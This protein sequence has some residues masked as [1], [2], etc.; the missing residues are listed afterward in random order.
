[1][2]LNLDRLSMEAAREVRSLREEIDQRVRRHQAKVLAAFQQVRV[3]EYLFRPSTGYGYGDRGREVLEELFAAVFHAEAALVRSQIVSGTHAI[4]LGMFGVLRPG[5]EMLLATGQPYDTLQPVVGMSTRAVGSLREWGVSVNQVDLTPEGAPDLAS[6]QVAVNPKTRLVFI[7]RSR[8]YSLRQP[9]RIEQIKLI[10]DVVRRANPEAVCLVDNC[11]G[12]FVEDME[13]TQVGAD[14]VAG[15]LIKNPGGGLAPTGGYLVGRYDLVAAAANVLT[16]PGIGGNVGAVPE[17]HRLYY[18]GLFMAPQVVGEALKGAVWTAAFCR[19]MGL[20][21]DPLPLE[22]RTDIIQA[23]L[24]ETPDRLVAWCQGLQ[25]GSPVDS[26]I[27]PRPSGMPGYQDRVVMAGGTFIQGAS[28]ELS[29]DGPLRPPF[30]VYQQGGLAEEY[31]RL[32]VLSAARELV[33]RGL[34]G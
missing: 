2:V 11:Y 22:H 25:K 5:D 9:V 13:P 31:V 27:A 28:I 10:I 18:Q 15:S 20:R 23:I 1:M 29:A 16:A 6:I 17:G 21:V 8:G 34:I 19:L 14:L 24:L 26:Y 7:Q 12:E 30:V 32:G 33:E 3:G 4:S